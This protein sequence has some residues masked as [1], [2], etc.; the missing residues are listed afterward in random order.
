MIEPRKTH[1]SEHKYLQLE[2]TTES[3][4]PLA[5]KKIPEKFLTN[6]L[7]LRPLNTETDP[8]EGWKVLRK[9]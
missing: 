9:I 1:R 7:P 2:P 4:R 3:G 8:V 6:I 5:Y